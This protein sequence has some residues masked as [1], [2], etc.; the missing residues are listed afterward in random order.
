MPAQAAMG[1]K[2]MI[3]ANSVADLES[4]G[5]LDLKADTIETTTLDSQGWKTFIQGL[6]DAGEV[7]LSGFFNP[8]D[9][10]GQ[11]A[12]YNAF[13][14]GTSLS[15]TILFP[16]GASWT[17]NGVVTGVKTDVQMADAVP[18]EATIKVSGQPSLGLTA[19]AKLSA[20]A[21]TGTGGTLAPAFS[22]AENLYSFSGVTTTSVT[23]TAT[24]AGQTIALYV[25]GVFNQFLTS[26]TASSAI[27]FPA[28]DAKKFTIVANEPNKAPNIYEITVVKTV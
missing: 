13:N 12:L 19:S 23:V 7:A 26:G 14:A 5:G 21:L 3:G 18:F 11:V 27:A 8:G 17:F 16:F 2:I 22:A 1:T 25:D 10:N 6:K 15:Y 24:G 20:L 4:I 28:I 9:T